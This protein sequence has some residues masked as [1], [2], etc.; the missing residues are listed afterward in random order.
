MEEFYEIA[1]Q[2]KH[3]AVEEV[4]ADCKKNK[5]PKDQEKKRI[6]ETQQLMD[7]KRKEGV[8]EINKIINQIVQDDDIS[9]QEKVARLQDM[10]QIRQYM[11]SYF[12]KKQE[13]DTDK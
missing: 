11:H 7:Q 2:K 3:E 1:F 12:E 10:E 9:V 8:N 5:T 13:V 6:Q 4:K